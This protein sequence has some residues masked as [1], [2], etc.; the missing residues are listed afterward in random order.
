MDGYHDNGALGLD[1]LDRLN[2][3]TRN[4]QA[5]DRGGMLEAQVRAAKAVLF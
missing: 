1:P 3:T 2:Q 4:A 5:T